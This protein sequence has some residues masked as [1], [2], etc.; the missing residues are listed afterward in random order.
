MCFFLSRWSSR[1]K[2]KKI[3]SHPSWFPV[4]NQR[5]RDT[6]KLWCFCC[7]SSLEGAQE[8]QS[9]LW[10]TSSTYPLV[11]ISFLIVFLVFCSNHY[12]WLYSWS[13]AS[14]VP[15]LHC[16]CHSYSTATPIVVISFLIALLVFCAKDGIL[17]L[18]AT[19]TT[20]LE[21]ILIVPN[22]SSD[23]ASTLQKEKK[24]PTAFGHRSLKTEWKWRQFC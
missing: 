5:F 15:I 6:D 20:H 10:T 23:G 17:L 1:N 12:S 11:V 18:P 3:Y 2:Q 4:V 8:R 19:A 22:L 16:R 13:G 21:V 9:F 7:P 14:W 24:E